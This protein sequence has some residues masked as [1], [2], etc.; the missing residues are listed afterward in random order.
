MHIISFLEKSETCIL[1][2]FIWAPWQT[3]IDTQ[4]NVFFSLIKN[5]KAIKAIFFEQLIVYISEHNM[6]ITP[7]PASRYHMFDVRTRNCSK[8]HTENNIYHSHDNIRIYFEEEHQSQCS[9][10]TNVLPLP[11]NES[12][13]ASQLNDRTSVFLFL[14]FFSSYSTAH[15]HTHTSIS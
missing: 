6:D 1:F 13:S 4:W 14:Y 9:S 2:Y 5:K 10:S 11:L 15:S 8:S 12:R 7:V 3:F